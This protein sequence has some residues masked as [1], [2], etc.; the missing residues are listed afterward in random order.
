MGE[1]IF[2]DGTEGDVMYGILEGEVEMYVHG[3]LIETL[4]AGNV[5]GVGSLLHDDRL[6]ESTAIAKTDCKLG[7]L[8]KSHFLFA[9][10]QTPMFGFEVIRSYS[11]RFRGLKRIFAS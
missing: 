6:R 8:D 5:F 2:E 1:V 10:Q 7:Y 9:V 3:K 4:T 11:D